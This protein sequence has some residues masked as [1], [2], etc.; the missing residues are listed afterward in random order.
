[1]AY[2]IHIRIVGLFIIVCISSSIDIRYCSYNG[3]YDSSRGE[4]EEGSLGGRKG[5]LVVCLI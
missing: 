1:M 2:T 3:P 5:C 4:E